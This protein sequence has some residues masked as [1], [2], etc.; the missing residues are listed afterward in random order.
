MLEEDFGLECGAVRSQKAG[1]QRPQ[2]GCHT[3]WLPGVTAE[4]RPFSSRLWMRD[5][6][7]TCQNISQLSGQPPHYSST[8]HP[9][10][11]QEVEGCVEAR[12]KVSDKHT[13]I[14]DRERKIRTEIECD[15]GNSDLA[16]RGVLQQCCLPSE[17]GDGGAK[18]SELMLGGSS[19]R[20]GPLGFLLAGPAVIFLMISLFCRKSLSP[21]ET[22]HF[23]HGETWRWT[24]P[25]AW[26]RY[27]CSHI[28]WDQHTLSSCLCFFAFFLPLSTQSSVSPF[29]LELPLCPR[30]GLT[31][32]LSSNSF[33]LTSKWLFSIPFCNT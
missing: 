12:S 30:G 26:T 22:R 24:R 11:P 16:E 17:G 9:Q 20:P 23:R 19:L 31:L 5:L 18:C 32:L 27:V 10:G 33:L 1:L 28:T 3:P 8:P 25:D 6:G 29:L 21:G 14:R 13:Q 15:I 4:P 7:L 2:C